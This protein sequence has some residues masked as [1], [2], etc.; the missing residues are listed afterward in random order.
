MYKVLAIG[1]HP[2]DIELG[3][4]ATLV[5]HNKHGAKVYL[6]ILTK[7]EASGDPIVREKEC[8]E[9]AR[10]MEAEDIFFGGLKDT[11]IDQSIRTIKTIE[12]VIN[13]IEP[14]II[15]THTYKDTHQDHRNTSYA[16]LS[17][18]RRSKKIFM[19]ESPTAL[20]EFSPHVYIDIEDEFL[21]KRNVLSL[22][23]SQSQK[24]WWSMGDRAVTAIEG[25]AAYR[26]FQAGLTY[27]EAYEIGRLV[28]NSNED[29]FVSS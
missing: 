20:S 15:Y 14:N 28:I 10:I 3:C 19:Y 8:K 17:A 7:G 2:D 12:N 23:S 13:K 26:G 25:L 9:S 4:S 16:T 24:E 1:A 21:I 18:G 22:F 27:A 6:L 5:R 29:L 11:K